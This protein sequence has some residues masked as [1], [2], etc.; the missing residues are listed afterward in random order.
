M[1]PQDH[2][3]TQSPAAGGGSRQRTPFDAVVGN[4]GNSTPWGDSESQLVM[5]D[6]VR[7]S[8]SVTDADLD[9]LQPAS[10]KRSFF[11]KRKQKLTP[12]PADVSAGVPANRSFSGLLPSQ[13][14]TADLDT[15]APTGIRTESKSFKVKGEVDAESRSKSSRW[16]SWGSN[17]KVP[18]ADGKGL[19][20]H[21]GKGASAQEASSRGRPSSLDLPAQSQNSSV[22]N[23]ADSSAQFAHM[24]PLMQ[25]GCMSMFNSG[26][27]QPEKPVSEVQWADS[28]IGN[29]AAYNSALSS[30]PVANPPFVSDGVAAEA[31]SS[32]GSDHSK[33]GRHADHSRRVSWDDTVLG[34]A[35]GGGAIEPGVQQESNNRFSS[36]FLTDFQSTDNSLSH[37]RAII[38]PVL[39]E[40]SSQPLKNTELSQAAQPASASTVAVGIASTSDTAFTS[41][42]AAADGEKPKKGHR[43]GRSLTGL[44]PT[45]NIKPKR[46]QSQFLE[47]EPTTPAGASGQASR[48]KTP[49]AKAATSNTSSLGQCFGMG[50]TIE[51]AEKEEMPLGV[52]GLRNLGNTCFVN[53]AL[54][55]LRY[56]PTLEQAIISDLLSLPAMDQQDPMGAESTEGSPVAMPS[57]TSS[58]E[59]GTELQSVP[60]SRTL[61]GG[62]VQL[63]SPSTSLNASS[64]ADAGSHMAALP[65]HHSS[66]SMAAQSQG[67]SPPQHQLGTQPVGI[68]VSHHSLLDHDRSSQADQLSSSSPSKPLSDR[69]NTSSNG[70]GYSVQTTSIAE[71]PVGIGTDV[72]TSGSDLFTDQPI[73]QQQPAGADSAQQGVASAVVEGDDSAR[74]PSSNAS[75][76]DKQPPPVAI[77]RVPLKRGEIADSFKTL[78]KQV[79]DKENQYAVDPG[80]FLRRI[81]QLPMG[82]E[83]CDG[84]Q[85]DAQELFRLLL[86]SL[87][88]DLNRITK[89]PAYEEDKDIPGEAET[90][91][92]D[93]LW[94]KYLDIDN[95]PITD[96]F[97]GQLQSTVHCHKCK[98]NF[99]TYEPFWDL[100]L[101]IVKDG[102]G[103]LGTWLSGK[104]IPTTIQGCLQAF[105]SDELLQGDESFKC[106]TCGEK[107]QASKQLR[108][109]RLPQ[110]LLLHIKRFK[111]SGSSREK[112]TNNVT[113]PVKG[114]KLNQFVSSVSSPADS[115]ANYDLYAVSNHFGSMAG[116]HY[117]A[118]C[119]VDLPGGREQ[120]Y[121]FNDDAVSKLAPQ[122][123]INPCA[124]MLFYV[125]T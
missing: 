14:T 49:D 111:Y 30:S 28:D 16:W 96:I 51:E 102:K 79:Y 33:L 57:A 18:K 104:S 34:T 86:D 7:R 35:G 73:D 112:L 23:G 3:Y 97:G 81:A 107:T 43:R 80:Q 82:A 93:R 44:I 27:L 75:T 2:S 61:D 4:S 91:K 1:A 99:T 118:A 24:S 94:R 101:P 70:S 89:K 52:K 9:E 74:G 77:P 12:E 113:F 8:R 76:L 72:S 60:E 106:E 42:T 54:Q 120:W 65:A 92:A 122:S 59:Q 67:Q 17:S 50:K 68:P 115:N 84:G 63:I 108:L 20:V 110:V 48:P 119:K 83:F 64:Q 117:T 19:P 114:L 15:R 90:D 5:S 66:H 31:G 69:L 45:L 58:A 6:L 10:R 103:G 109:Y 26:P 124:Y 125:R 41:P 36:P 100:S 38:N 88:D 116:G 53:V 13:V 95:S 40:V 62:L 47:A 21:D 85:H 78:V 25:S 55:C 37:N 121:N 71:S 11:S 32:P 39:P 22:M 105:T 87:H 98:G 56:T 123:V 46:S 29:A